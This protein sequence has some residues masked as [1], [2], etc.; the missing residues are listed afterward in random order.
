MNIV[1][2]DVDALG[3]PYAGGQARRTFEINRRLA[4]RHEVTVITA[5]HSSLHAET[6]A[7]VR[8]VR[9][10]ALP[11]PANFMWYFLEIIPRA[12][13]AKA[14]L[15]AEDFCA[16]FSATGLPAFVKPPVVAIASNLFA[17]QTTRKYHLP[18]DRI[19]A[20]MIG[21]YRNLI[22]LTA[23][24]SA[25]L[26]RS[27]PRAAIRIIPNGADPGAFNAP[28]TGEEDY[29][30]F[31]GRLD[32]DQKGLDLLLDVA[33]QLPEGLQLRIA[34]AGKGEGWL[35]NEIASRKLGVRVRFVGKLEGQDRH[36][37]LARA[38]AMAL[39]SRYENQPL[40]GL[41]AL[42]IG[43]PIVSFDIAGLRDVFADCAVFVEAFDTRRF[44]DALV[45]LAQNRERA[46]ALSQ[47]ARQRGAL[48]TWDE[49]ARAQEKFYEDIVAAGQR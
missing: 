5:G 18:F 11:H 41:D 13:R 19:E 12:V 3:A 46:A 1:H 49:A 22:A 26:Q 39:T 27:A 34:G 7:G 10:A 36:L 38:K 16:P 23:T 31:L 21:R 9:M 45:A 40:V 30:A 44:A 15:L 37:F 17:A 6:I 43:V 2:F 35:R 47:R 32:P 42:A 28:W 4:A 8:Y 24:Q 20:A 25:V 29:V 33:A 14:D 48:F